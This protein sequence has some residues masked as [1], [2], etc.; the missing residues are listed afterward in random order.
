M[1]NDRPLQF[2]VQIYSGRQ[3]E[4]VWHK[5][6][7]L[8]GVIPEHVFQAMNPKVCED[9]GLCGKCGGQDTKCHIL[10][11]IPGKE[12]AYEKLCPILFVDTVN[13]DFKLK[14]IV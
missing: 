1:G 12:Y 9:L 13:P 4:V 8:P 3:K 5:F 7:L 2:M 14:D 6:S 11:K 10:W